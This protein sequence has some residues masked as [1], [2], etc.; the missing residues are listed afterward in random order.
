MIFFIVFI[1]FVLRLISINQSFWLDE[2]INVVFA[3]SLSYKNLILN[4]PLGD[5]HPPLFHI[6]LK[7]FLQIFTATELSARM[8]SVIFGALTVYVI[9]LIGKKLYDIKTGLIAATLLATAPLHIYYSQEAR[10][11]VMAAFFTSLSVY[12][13]IS[14]LNK[15]KI[16]YLIGF[17]L[18]TTLM[19]Y[20]DY[21]PYFM[22]PIYIIYLFLFRKN[23]PKSTLYSFAPALLLILILICPWLYFIPKQLHV[24]LTA[25]A[26]SPA[27]A[28]VVGSSDLKALLIT[29]VKFTI[30]RISI[31]NDLI[32]F[33]TFVPIAIFTLVLFIL[34]AFR[35]SPKRSFLLIWLFGPIIMAFIL[36]FFI[37]VFSY[38]RLIFTLGAFYLIWASAI[39]TINLAK[40]IRVLLI[41]ALAI[42][43]TSLTIYF[44]NTK[45][46]R[47][48]WRG[49]THY[50]QLN[51]TSNTIVLFETTDSI[52][53][54][55]FYNQSKI[56]TFGALDNWSPTT[57][58][59]ASKLN[60]ITQG[61][62]KIFL[63]QY[64]SPITDPQGLVFT[65][66][67]KEGFSNTS[68]KDFHGVGFVYEF[69]KF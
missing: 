6:I 59:V 15:D 49:A 56:K 2:G 7:L 10:M 3:K 42:N 33:I 61:K 17:V 38:F 62:E 8:P 14:I 12:F 44:L 25:S 28:S 57:E 22:L 4:Y 69:K 45:F 58:Q 11:Y 66:L 19:L 67:T 32:Y 48:D 55:D 63:F 64:L 51:S 34:H 29:L 21:V 47:E 13:F 30:G 60:S 24:G 46:Q 50:V 26:L 65:Q 54:F 53:P 39:N 20:T 27:W 43:I 37:P 41:I 36:S 68:T 9:Y 40:S 31:D 5:F 23:I 16:I 18:S 35:L 52:A 1:S